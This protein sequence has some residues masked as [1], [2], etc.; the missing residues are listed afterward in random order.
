MIGFVLKIFLLRSLKVVIFLSSL[1]VTTI[2]Y[3]AKESSSS[4]RTA[5]MTTY[6]SKVE[7]ILKKFCYDC[8]GPKKAKADLRLDTLNPNLLEGEDAEKWQ[9]VLDAISV[10]DMPPEKKEQLSTAQRHV[11]T[12]WMSS[13]LKKAT[14]VKWQSQKHT[15]FRRMTKYEYAYTLQDLLG[16]SV[17]IK[18]NMAEELYSPEGFQNNS[19]LLFVSPSQFDA[20]QAISLEA[21]KRSIFPGD[22][23]KQFW[24]SIPVRYPEP[25]PK[26]RFNVLSLVKSEEKPK[27]PSIDSGVSIPFDYRFGGREN[28]FMFNLGQDLPDTGIVRVRMRVTKTSEGKKHPRIRVKFGWWATHSKT[29]EMI[30]AKIDVDSPNGKPTFYEFNIDLAQVPRNPFRKM[31]D[32]DPRGHR[33]HKYE[34]IYTANIDSSL[35]TGSRSTPKDI[36]TFNI[37][38]IEMSPPL[39]EKW[40]PHSHSNIFIT[41]KNSANKPVYAKEIIKSFMTKAYRRPVENDE[42]NRAYVLYEKIEKN[43]KSFQ[44][45]ILKVLSIILS[46]PEFVYLVE[47]KSSGKGNDVSD[48]ELASRLSYFI[49]CSMP[50]DELLNLAKSKKLNNPSVLSKQLKRMLNDSKAK[51]FSEKFSFQ[52]LGL[53]Q[54]KL[55]CV[56]KKTHSSYDNGLKEAIA[57]EPFHFFNEVLNKN[58]SILTFINSDFVMVNARLA[59]HYGIKDVYSHDF[60]RVKIEEK[61]HRGGVLGQ[62][63]FLSAASDGKDS[64]PIKRGMWLLERILDDSP[65]PPP[66]SAPAIDDEDPSLVGLTLKQKL[67]VHRSREVCMDCHKK[68]DPWGV[69]FENYSAIG[70][71]REKVTRRGI[72]SVNVDSSVTLTDGNK[73]KGIKDL[74]TY[75]LTHKKD[76]FVK[77]FI[78][79]MCSYALGRSLGYGDREEVDLIYDQFKKANYK[80]ADLVGLIVTSELFRTK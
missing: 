26:P 12:E 69:V 60:H 32:K 33:M 24:Y 28:D 44:D 34:K 5:D 74:Q 18:D 53:E 23:P 61:H 45:S 73:L 41:S 78:H 38:Y 35:T 30:V 62:A 58:M 54:L 51:R 64:H 55:L 40:P 68:I 2:D 10:G 17:D 11:V 16:V 63:A 36:A 25:L 66:A 77:G 59:R 13:E 22:Q 49:W 1:L 46:Y 31:S 37:D 67:E 14:E 8:H 75:L 19:K 79:K 21:L 72:K 39:Y 71:W 48:Y 57:E 70:G 56:D 3:C 29:E 15:S 43:K 7:P 20:Y 52:W 6:K 27:I 80:L 65:P 47:D 76:K 50:D 4:Y 42:L 9:E